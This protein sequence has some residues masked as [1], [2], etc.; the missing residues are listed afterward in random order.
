MTGKK[1]KSN[2]DK[3]TESSITL[4]L[5]S[6]D[7]FRISEIPEYNTLKSFHLKEM[8]FCWWQG[9]EKTIY[10]L[11]LKSYR[12]ARNALVATDIR[13]NLIGKAVDS[14]F[15]ILSVWSKTGIGRSIG[16][17]LPANFKAY[18]GDGK[19]KIVFLIDEHP[20]HPIISIISDAIKSRLKGKMGLLN[21]QHIV[22]YNFAAAKARLPIS[23]DRV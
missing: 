15:L 16:Q 22:V 5:P 21:I 4:S 1:T 11:E 19:T 23:I 20:N 10:L 7:Y 13:E 6:G 9:S 3:I 17:Q 14:L 12:L 8:D 2:F 18:P